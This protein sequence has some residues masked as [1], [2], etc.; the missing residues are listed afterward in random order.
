VRVLLIGGGHS[1]VAV[2][3]QFGLRPVADV[4]LTLVSRGTHTPYSGML[5]GL[6]AG[7]Y[8][9]EDAHIDLRRLARFARARAVFDEAVGL[10]PLARRVRCAGGETRSY[11]LVS[12]DIGSTPNTSVPGADEHAIAV[13]PIDRFLDRWNALRVR[14]RDDRSPRRIAVVGGGAG[15]VEL[16]LSVQFALQEMLRRHGRRVDRLEFHLFTSDGVILAAHNRRVQAIFERIMRERGVRVHLDSTIVA[17]ESGV[18][19]DRRGRTYRADEVLWTTEA[20]AASWIGESGLEVDG[21][22][23]VRV[24]ATLESVSHP[25]VFA[26]GDVA[27]LVGHRLP[28]SGVYAVRQGEILAP[29]LRR[30]AEGK[31]LRRYRPQRHAL[32]LVSTGDKYAV[33]SRGP[34]SIAGRWVWRWKDAIDRAFVRK[35]TEL[36]AAPEG[37]GGERHL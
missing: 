22:G 4:E 24:A 27:S 34:L 14:M 8:G 13:K 29:N 21:D 31:P 18:V 26:A 17:V 35:Y 23:F 12:I 37:D 2:L 3:K 30:A 28:K 19:R 10:D 20:R 5:P 16:V 6:V 1:H 25:G 36:P 7:H 15:G 32:S 11:D 9:F 33:A